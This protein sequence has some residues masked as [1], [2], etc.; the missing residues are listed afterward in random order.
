MPVDVVS[1]ILS[2]IRMQGSLYFSTRFTPPWSILVPAFERVC[3][4]HLVVRGQCWVRV[5][6][7][8][9]PVLLR[10]GDLIVIPHGQEHTLADEAE[11]QPLALDEVLKHAGFRGEGALVY[12]GEATPEPRSI[13]SGAE[14]SMVCGHFVF[15]QAMLH[16]LLAELPS[17]LVVR[18]EERGDTDW[19]DRTIEFVAS[20][21]ER[22][23]I[24]REAIVNR[25][26]EIFFVHVL[27]AHVQRS[28]GGQGFLA[29]LK[30]HAIGRVLRAIHAAPKQDWTVD[31][32]ARE[33]GLSRTVLMERFN[34]SVG[35]PPIGYLTRWRMQI[36]KRLLS[37]TRLPIK[38][39]GHRVGYT[40]GRA[41]VR[42]FTREAG[43]TP[44]M[45]RRQHEPS[46]G[47]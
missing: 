12:S 42:A 43:R 29:A 2:V 11:R 21:V 13:P 39:I 3:R 35:M 8:S 7:A 6:D 44:A 31:D 20:E 14:T 17:H 45:F 32:L 26:S 16:P 30:D 27:R 24:G 28:A 4:Y 15:D 19:L 18:K 37:D 23:E 41:F 40:A 1:E 38:E 10:A 33:A 22:D 34:A 36:A 46:A 5:R 47:A 9:A 25:C